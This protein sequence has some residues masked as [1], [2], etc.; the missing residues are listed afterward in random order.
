MA[1]CVLCTP[2]ARGQTTKRP[3]VCVR[4]TVAVDVVICLSELVQVNICLQ[5]LLWIYCPGH[6]RVREMT[7]E[8][9]WHVKKA[10]IK[11]HASEKT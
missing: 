2:T 3:V 8:I 11:C 10:S 1:W 5:R 4:P 7:K 6:A 9:D